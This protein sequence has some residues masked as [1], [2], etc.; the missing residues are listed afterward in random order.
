[1]LSPSALASSVSPNDV[2][3]TN[4]TPGHATGDGTPTPVR[5]TNPTP[6]HASKSVVTNPRPSNPTPKHA[7]ENEPNESPSYE[8]ASGWRTNLTSLEEVVVPEVPHEEPVMEPVSAPAE[9]DEPEDEPGPILFCGESR[10]CALGDY[11]VAF[12]LYF[13]ASQS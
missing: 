10:N 11:R 12:H 1:M 5:P 7:A 8:E 3:P 13:K 2:R 9:P 6:V 4:P